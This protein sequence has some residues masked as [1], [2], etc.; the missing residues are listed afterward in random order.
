MTTRQLTDLS[1]KRRWETLYALSFGFSALTALSFVFIASTLGASPFVVVIAMV[2][3]ATVTT[4]V[5]LALLDS[6]GDKEFTAYATAVERKVINT[7]PT[8]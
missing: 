2:V 3:I 4:C 7:V 8:N 1:R 6:A 5:L